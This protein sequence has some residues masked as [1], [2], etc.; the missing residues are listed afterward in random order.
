MVFHSSEIEIP[1]LAEF[2]YNKSNL[3][4]MPMP[5]HFHNNC[6]EFVI[7]LRG[8]ESYFTDGESFNVSG[9]EVFISH[10]NRL[11]RNSGNCQGISEFIWFQLEMTDRSNF[12]G[13]SKAY[14]AALFDRLLSIKAH[15]IK[16]DKKC[17]C[18]IKEA[19]RETQKNNKYIAQG[20]FLIFLYRLFFLDE[21]LQKADNIMEKAIEYIN[22]NIEKN[23]GID[24]L[25]SCCALSESAFKY[26]FK[27]YTG[28]TPRQYINKMKVSKA[29]ELLLKGLSITDTAMELSFNSCDYFSV[30][31]RKHT[32]MTPSQFKA[33]QIPGTVEKK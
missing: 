5:D 9:G 8:S 11:H 30:V 32:L 27:D 21:S 29:K 16:T 22:G 7:V 17:I 13:L 6:M 12:L 19:F 24:E 20:L 26:K 10:L 14:S 28:D 2:G 18:L 3:V 15:K 1:G 31:F 33:G 25:S 23:I 4:T